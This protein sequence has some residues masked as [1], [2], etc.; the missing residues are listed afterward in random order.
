MCVFEVS[1]ILDVDDR[2][3]TTECGTIELTEHSGAYVL[4][5]QFECDLGGFQVFEDALT[6]AAKR[7]LITKTKRMSKLVLVMVDRGDI[8]IRHVSDDGGAIS[9]YPW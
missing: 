5:D 1:W 7:L 3:M 2:R 9:E 6:E 8:L 4:G